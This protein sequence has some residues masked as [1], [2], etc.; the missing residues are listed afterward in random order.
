MTSA[1][2][3]LSFVGM[4]ELSADR[5]IMRRKSKLAVSIPVA[6]LFLLLAAGGCGSQVKKLSEVDA[7][8]LLAQDGKE[9]KAFSDQAGVILASGSSIKARAAR[10]DAAG[11][12]Y[13][14][15]WPGVFEKQ[16]NSKEW[17]QAVAKS[18][19]GDQEAIYGSLYGLA[20]KKLVVQYGR[21]SDAVNVPD[22]I[23]GAANK[24]YVAL[25]YLY[26][27]RDFEGELALYTVGDGTKIKRDNPPP[28]SATGFGT[29][30]SAFIGFD[31]NSDTGDIILFKYQ[32]DP[33]F[34]TSGEQIT[35]SGA[36]QFFLGQSRERIKESDAIAA[37]K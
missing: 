28:K 22:Y 11:K 1:N 9:V 19:G 26:S 36:E 18:K 32:T 34:S 4:E 14:V 27:L 23:S 21:Q 20:Q 5:W 25:D 8:R 31:W 12:E 35:V 6:F 10:F 2:V 30:G 3:V 7:K 29:F 37:G 13:Q 24:Y 33:Q 16:A 15:F 17:R